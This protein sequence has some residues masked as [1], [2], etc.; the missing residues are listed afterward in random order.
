LDAEKWYSVKQKD[1]KEIVCYFLFCLSH[2][3]IPTPVYFQ[4]GGKTL[5]KFYE[6]SHIRAFQSIYPELNLKA[7]KFS[8]QPGRSIF[9][10]TCKPFLINLFPVHKGTKF[11]LE[12]ARSKNFD[13]LDAEKW[14]SITRRDIMEAVCSLVTST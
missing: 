7:E 5:L 14:Y 3:E 8:K 6:D 10:C 13:P 4:K 1:I 2:V 12:L 9:Q 11:F